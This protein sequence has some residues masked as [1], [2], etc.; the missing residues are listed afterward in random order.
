M[1]K[2]SCSGT[3]LTNWVLSQVN[4]QPGVVFPKR[5]EWFFHLKVFYP[6]GCEKSVLMILV[7]NK[8]E[9]VL[10]FPVDETI[11]AQQI[12]MAIK[13]AAISSLLDDFEQEPSQQILLTCEKQQHRVQELLDEIRVKTPILVLSAEKVFFSRGTFENSRLEY[14]LSQLDYDPDLISGFIHDNFTRAGESIQK[15]LFYQHLFH[16]LNCLCLQGEKRVSLRSIVSTSIPCWNNFRRVD[17]KMMQQQIQSDLQTVF[18]LFFKN[19]LFLE[20]YQKKVGSQSDLV[21]TLPDLP[22]T[23][24]SMSDWSNKQKS[25]LEY[26]HKSVKTFTTDEL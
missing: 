6:P 19:L 14:R 1:F 15:S 16:V 7:A 18:D 2:Y 11:N 10:F 21:I 25:A 22:K 9:C 13:P 4:N 12:K 17:Q 3:H 24:R 26:L 8:K 23:R 5:K 20:P